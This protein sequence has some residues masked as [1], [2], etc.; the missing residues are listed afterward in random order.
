[1]EEKK[2]KREETKERDVHTNEP[3][4]IANRRGRYRVA[5]CLN[6]FYQFDGIQSPSSNTCSIHQPPITT[7]P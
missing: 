6:T 2:K 7:K 4:Q 1:M 3:E 5:Q